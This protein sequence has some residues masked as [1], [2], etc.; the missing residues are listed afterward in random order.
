M[1]KKEKPE[2]IL[3]L[4]MRLFKNGDI[5]M[6][7]IQD[8]EKNE[9]LRREVLK[10]IAEFLG[11]LPPTPTSEKEIKEFIKEKILPLTDEDIE[12]AT[13]KEIDSTL[14]KNPKIE[15]YY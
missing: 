14:T 6:E 3:L 13:I 12:R 1:E 5:K 9:E 15:Q 11:K 10:S 4:K 7:W 8:I 2:E